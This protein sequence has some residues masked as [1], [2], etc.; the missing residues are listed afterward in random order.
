[1]AL[2]SW[3]FYIFELLPVVFYVLF[4]QRNRHQGLQVIF[5]YCLI[6]F[7]TEILAPT[8]KR[9]FEINVFYSLATFTVIEYSLLTIFLYQSIQDRRL[10]YVP[11]VG[12]LVF[13]PVAIINF[14][15][16]RI[17]SF[18]STSASI[19]AILIIIYSL[20]FLYGQ[21]KDP[22][23]LF[24]YNTKKF[25]VVS[26]FFIYFSSTLFLFLYAATLTK[27]Q[28]ANYWY[29]NNLFD[30]IKNILFCIAFTMKA[31]NK[32]ENPFENNYEDSYEDRSL[33]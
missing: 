19:E 3:L 21:I 12:S 4:L 33:T 14:L 23:I 1:M 25:W 32:S 22:A 26:A 24:V 11:I 16:G 27:E 5:F 8:L 30:I 2:F 18:D 31:S 15:Q 29:I 28:R 13:F 6:S 9:V 17:T 7:G 20:L 10:K